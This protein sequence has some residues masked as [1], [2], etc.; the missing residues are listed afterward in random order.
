MG[1]T[2]AQ[3]HVKIAKECDKSSTGLS[4]RMGDNSKVNVLRY[5]N[6]TI[7]DEV[8]NTIDLNNTRVVKGMA[9]TIISLLQL[10][11]EG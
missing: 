6:V 8:G 5:E 7:E 1:D 2:G 3:C 11:G 4:V 10:V 9:T